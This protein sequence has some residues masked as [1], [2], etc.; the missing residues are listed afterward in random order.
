MSCALV[1]P[2]DGRHRENREFS[3]ESENLPRMKSSRLTFLPSCSRQPGSGLQEVGKR[4]KKNLLCALISS[5]VP[6]SMVPLFTQ[7]AWLR[8]GD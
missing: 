8:S 6:F 2:L 7:S 4:K 1:A 3:V 5:R